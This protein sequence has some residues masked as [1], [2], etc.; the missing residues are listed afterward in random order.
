MDPIT[1]PEAAQT[2]SNDN[3]LQNEQE[4]KEIFYI[5][6]IDTKFYGEHMCILT[7]FNAARAQEKAGKY[8]KV[9]RADPDSVKVYSLKDYK[10]LYPKEPQA[11]LVFYQNCTGV[12]HCQILAPNRVEAGEKFKSRFQDK[13]PLQIVLKTSKPKSRF[14]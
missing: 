10:A 1:N 13:E 5:F 3:A 14:N 8:L 9:K 7:A 11:F 12:R 2:F 4:A 6:F